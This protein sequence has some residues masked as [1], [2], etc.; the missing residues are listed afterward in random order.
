[1][2]ALIRWAHP[3]KGLIAPAEFI[4]LAEE[5]GIIREI[6]EWVITEACK[7]NKEWQ[8]K[9]YKKVPIAVN[10]STVQLGKN[11]PQM[12]ENILSDSDLPPEWLEFEITE[13]KIMEVIEENIDILKKL[14]EIGV[15]I[16][17]DDFGTGYSSLSYLRQLPLDV[18]K[19]DKSF[20]SDIESSNHETIIT[21]DIISIAHK[22]SL[23]VIA[24]GVEDQHQM[25][26]L[27]NQKCDFL[28]GF[29]FSKPLNSQEMED[30]FKKSCTKKY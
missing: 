29:F 18:I 9:G 14:K 15:R 7:K 19:I 16:S 5:T 20:I 6:G 27:V 30:L 17:I 28:Q 8:Q 25:D 24:E 10:I 22:L 21:S 4:P 13:S 11:S 23:Q 3:K 12:I 26:Y 2:E 1:M